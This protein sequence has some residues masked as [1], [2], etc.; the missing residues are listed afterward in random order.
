MTRQA[1]L[2]KENAPKLWAIMDEA[3]IRR[4]VGGRDV[5]RGQ[6][7]HMLEA[8]SLPNVTIQMIPFGVGAH[9]GM[10]GSFVILDFPEDDDPSIVYID[11]G[12]GGLFLEEVGEIRRY[13]LMFEH[14][15]AAASGLD[16]TAALLRAIVSEI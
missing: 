15:R 5:M 9:P 6:I 7:E 8:R 11:S 10:D 12:A 1:I 16:A 14:L 4:L 13:K 3:V 2:V